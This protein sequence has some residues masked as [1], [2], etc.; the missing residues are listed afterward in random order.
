MQ[1]ACYCGASAA[2][3]STANANSDNARMTSSNVYIAHWFRCVHQ[4]TAKLAARA[5]AVQ[6]SSA[7]VRHVIC[8]PNETEATRWR[9]SNKNLEPS[10]DLSNTLPAFRVMF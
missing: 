1:A 6:L 4:R 5:R 8:T 7:G 2:V 9:A 10:L 3:N